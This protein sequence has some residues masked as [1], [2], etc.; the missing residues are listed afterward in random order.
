MIKSD[1]SKTE[2]NVKTQ[3]GVLHVEFRPALTMAAMFELLPRVKRCKCWP[4][5][6]QCLRWAEQRFGVVA[7]IKWR[8]SKAA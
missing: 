1:D 2:M 3:A 5:V 4:S 7:T 6:G 8:E